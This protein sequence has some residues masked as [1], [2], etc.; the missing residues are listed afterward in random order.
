M[1][2]NQFI[3]E[4]SYGAEIPIELIGDETA[5]SPYVAMDDA[6]KIEAARKGGLIADRFG[7]HEQPLEKPEYT[8]KKRR[9]R[10]E[11]VKNKYRRCKKVKI[12]EVTFWPTES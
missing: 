5:W 1:R 6:L 7:G 9:L 2:C 8:S 12:K 11:Q 10:P 3:D 4:G